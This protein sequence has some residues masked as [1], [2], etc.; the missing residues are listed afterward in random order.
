[1]KPLLSPAVYDGDR[2][3]LHACS[4]KDI[5]ESEMSSTLFQVPRLAVEG[6]SLDIVIV[7]LVGQGVWYHLSVYSLV[8]DFCPDDV[9]GSH[10]N[11][12]TFMEGVVV[13]DKCHPCFGEH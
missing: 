13:E 6:E 12:L 8:H 5:R 9:L 2:T 4:L 7:R 11:W 10:S 3:R 1:M